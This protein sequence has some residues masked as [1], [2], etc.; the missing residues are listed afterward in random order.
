MRK[1]LEDV[2]LYL[3]P[4]YSGNTQGLRFDHEAAFIITGAAHTFQMNM[5]NNVLHSKDSTGKRIYSDAQI[6][7]L[8]SELGITT[9]EINPLAKESY[10]DKVFVKIDKTGLA[11]KLS[12][13][14]SF[15]KYLILKS[16]PD[17]VVEGAAELASKPTATWILTTNEDEL[18]QEAGTSQDKYRGMSIIYKNEKDPQALRDMLSVYFEKYGNKRKVNPNAPIDTIQKQLFKY[19]DSDPINFLKIVEDENYSEELMVLSAIELG[20]IVSRGAYY[21][22]NANL[23]VTIASSRDELVKLFVD[24][25]KEPELVASMIREIETKKKNKLK[26]TK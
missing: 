11:L 6:A 14:K 10:W 26:L 22:H 5:T 16:Y 12:D 3:K 24:P 25:S 8:A 4:Y 7:K 20:V 1:I 2:T 19:A 9:D 21:Y 23:A 15:A 13:P 17:V 18:E